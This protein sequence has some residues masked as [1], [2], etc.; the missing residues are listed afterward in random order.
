[1]QILQWWERSGLGLEHRLHVLDLKMGKEGW[2]N[3]RFKVGFMVVDVDVGGIDGGV[4]G[5]CEAV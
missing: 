1:M 3:K 4:W 5:Y 2:R